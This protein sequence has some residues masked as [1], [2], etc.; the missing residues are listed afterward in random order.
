MDGNGTYLARDRIEQVVD[1]GPAE[2]ALLVLVHLDDLAPV[3][4]DLGQVEALGEVDEV[5]DVLL[6]A[7]AAEADG[8][9]EELGAHARVAADGVGDL[10][11][12]GAGGLADGGEGVD[13]GDALGEHRVCGLRAGQRAWAARSVSRQG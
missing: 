3:R 8:G 9:L 2:P 7:R 4:G 13:G 12:V 10:V 1:D 11:N 6:E 5:E